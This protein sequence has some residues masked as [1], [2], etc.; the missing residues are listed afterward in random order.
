MK[1]SPRSFRRQTT[2]LVPRV[3]ARRRLDARRAQRAGWRT[4]QS[5]KC[6]LMGKFNDQISVMNLKNIRLIYISWFSF[7][8][9]RVGETVKKTPHCLLCR[10]KSTT[11]RH[12]G[13]GR[14]SANAT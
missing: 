1:I 13:V 14:R 8:V 11:R 10:R 7:K 2:T 6:F 12:T 9:S 4:T 5:I 3:R